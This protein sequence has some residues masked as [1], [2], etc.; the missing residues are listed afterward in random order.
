VG[1]LAVVGTLV[2]LEGLL[3]ADNALVLALLVQHLP[4]KQQ[5]RALLYG[6]VGAFVLRGIG[7]LLAAYI[8]GLWWLC[9][10]GALYLIF[11]A[12]KHFVARGG[13]GQD[14]HGGVPK[15]GMSFWHT[16]AV[17]EFTD[18]VFAVD[19]ILVA[20]A[21]VNDPK[22]MWIVYTGGFLGII[23]LRMAAGIFIKLIR[24]YPALDDMAYALVGWAGVKLANTALHLFGNEYD[25]PVPDLMPKPLFWAVFTLIVLVGVW[26]ARRSAGAPTEEEREVRVEA[27]EALETLRDEGLVDDDPP[28]PSSVAK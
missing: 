9:G 16:V 10:I 24:K 20:V 23:L 4:E 27:G 1:D 28:K 22:K 6:L 3:S 25:R 18:V 14:E 2:L 11:L 17:V 7:I 13:H 8:I 19:S 21:L 5:H 15:K 12:A 26:S